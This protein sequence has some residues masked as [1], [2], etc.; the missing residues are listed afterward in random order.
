VA[1]YFRVWHSVPI[2][3][4]YLGTMQ[5]WHENNRVVLVLSS[6][7]F[8]QIRSTGVREFAPSDFR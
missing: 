6:S 3:G 7:P 2:R 8:A 5:F 4:A 1:Q